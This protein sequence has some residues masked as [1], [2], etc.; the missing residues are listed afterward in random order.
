MSYKEDILE[1][2]SISELLGNANEIVLFNDDHNS[3]DHVIETLIRVC[4]HTSI[5]AEQCSLIVHYNGRCGIKTGTMKELEPM[6]SKLLDA[7]LTVEIQ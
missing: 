7:G 5:Q 6:C 3:F 1:E 2:V 4:K